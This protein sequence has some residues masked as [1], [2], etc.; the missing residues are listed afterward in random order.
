MNQKIKEFI[1]KRKYLLTSSDDRESLFNFICMAYQDLDSISRKELIDEILPSVISQHAITSLLWKRLEMCIL[2]TLKHW[3]NTLWKNS[4]GDWARLQQV[5]EDVNH[6]FTYGEIVDHLIEN[7]NKLGLK[8]IPL[9]PAY[10]R[11]DGT[12]Y[13]L[14]GIFDKQRYKIENPDLFGDQ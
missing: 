10:A 8:M 13:D 3:K 5:L 2:D 9:E 4:S 12:D 6:D 1:Y 14:L 7:K 11:E